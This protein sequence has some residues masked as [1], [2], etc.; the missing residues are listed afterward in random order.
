MGN[1]SLYGEVLF[2]E[3]VHLTI[4]ASK[5]GKTILVEKYSREQSRFDFIIAS[6]LKHGYTI[7]ETE[8]EYNIP[9]EEARRGIARLEAQKRNR[10]VNGFSK[11]FKDS[12][13]VRQ[14]VDI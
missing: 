3:Y 8:Y 5:N 6:L 11:N 9:R 14:A 2:P 7:D 10:N 4:A 13:K 12:H 1:K